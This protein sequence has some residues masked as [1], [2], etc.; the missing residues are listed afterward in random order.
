VV[1]GIPEDKLVTIVSRLVDA[2]SPRQV[3]LFGSHAYG[4]PHADSD[5][6]ILVTVDDELLERE[7]QD[8][9]GYRSLRGLFLPIELHF[10]GQRQFER[11]ANISGSFEHEVRVKGRL[12]YAA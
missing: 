9:R 10:L 5:V 7:D 4:T 12:L 11:R 6:D 8:E 1:R 3:Y 2:V